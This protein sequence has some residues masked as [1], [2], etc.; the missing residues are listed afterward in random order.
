MSNSETIPEH[1]RPLPQLQDWNR[2]FFEGGF[3][4][5]LILQ[6][7]REC[8]RY[9]YYPR[10]ICHHCASFDLEW[11]QVSGEATLFSF[12][13]VWSPEHPYFKPDV[14]ITIGTVELQIGPMMFARIQTDDETELEIGMALE[15][16]FE[17][18]TDDIALPIFRPTH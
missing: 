4:N 12:T 2:P 10:P 14:P 11:V 18:V 17:K 15:V 1:I 5:E 8:D 3:R 9:I 6:R 16:E 13:K 7:C